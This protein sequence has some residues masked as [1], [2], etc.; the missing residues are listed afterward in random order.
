MSYLSYLNLVSYHRCIHLISDIGMVS[1]TEPYDYSSRRGRKEPEIL[2]AA[3]VKRL[4]LQDMPYL[5]GGYCLHDSMTQ[6]SEEDK[7]ITGSKISSGMQNRTSNQGSSGSILSMADKYKYMRETFRKRLAFG[8]DSPPFL[9]SF[10]LFSPWAP[11]MHLLLFSYQVRIPKFIW[12]IIFIH[13]ISA[14]VTSFMER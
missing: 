3:S 1:W 5:V 6:I 11:K 7:I 14:F 2:A 4:F 10:V 9:S 13:L 8:E 12:V